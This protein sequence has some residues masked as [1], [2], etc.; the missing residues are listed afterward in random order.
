M[1]PEDFNI[2]DIAGQCRDRFPVFKVQIGSVATRFAEAAE[3]GP[4][5]PVFMSFKIAGS[6]LKSAG[7]MRP[8]IPSRQA[9]RAMAA[10][11]PF[12]GLPHHRQNPMSPTFIS[13][14]NEPLPLLTTLLLSLAVTALPA[15][16]ADTPGAGSPTVGAVPSG[17]LAASQTPLW[18]DPDQ[19]LALRITNL[20]SLMT[21]AEK[22]GQMCEATPSIPRL[23]IPAYNY[24]NECLHG[25]ARNNTAYATVFPQAIGMAAAWD[26]PML[27][28][29]RTPSPPRRAPCTGFTPSS[30][31]AT[32]RS[33]WA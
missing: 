11:D 10:A 20:I 13:I 25:V 23:N 31:T 33:S 22:C 21:L 12:P 4:L 27:H 2:C 3:T 24:W 5:T 9:R 1:A 15:R 28:T 26:A 6:M 18:R 29:S 17:T 19:P 30:M 14:L 7:R 8:L 32:A 16:A